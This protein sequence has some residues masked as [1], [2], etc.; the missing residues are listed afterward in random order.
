MI[1]RPPRS[2]LFPCATLFRPPPYKFAADRPL[3]SGRT[4]S[5]RRFGRERREFAGGSAPG[6]DAAAAVLLG[7]GLKLRWRRPTPPLRVTSGSRRP[8][9]LRATSRQ[10]PL[11]V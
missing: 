4:A 6:S 7:H 3:F 5:S 9:C 10:P 2:T 1:R 8:L 11:H